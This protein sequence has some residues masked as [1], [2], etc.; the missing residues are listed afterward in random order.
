MEK[1]VKK[2]PKKNLTTC[3]TDDE[4]IMSKK[5][6]SSKSDANQDDGKKK[7]G[8]SEDPMLAK[9]EKSGA[10]QDPVPEIPDFMLDLI[11][12]SSYR[13]SSSKRRSFPEKLA[14]K[15]VNTEEKQKK[16]SPCKIVTDKNKIKS[17]KKTKLEKVTL[18]ILEKKFR[19]KKPKYV[20]GLAIPSL[21]FK[22]LFS[23]VPRP[24]ESEIDNGLPSWNYSPLDAKL[25]IIPA[26]ENY[27][28]CSR[29]KVG[30]KVL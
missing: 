4:C 14:Q 9:K 1:P 7:L 28:V 17:T 15:E 30:E 24:K 10:A 20:D 19:E 21:P 25:L 18:D 11:P 12:R 23:K 3:E 6:K 16:N 22:E 8:E 27:F 13:T 29:G 5:E 2:K 26:P